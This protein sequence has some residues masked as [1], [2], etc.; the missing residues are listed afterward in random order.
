MLFAKN[1]KLIMIGDSV[2]DAGREHPVGEYGAGRGM[3]YVSEVNA[4]LTTCYPELKMRV[5]NMGTSGNNVLDLANRWQT[6]VFDL[7]PAWVSV[8]IGIN[9]IW[10]QFDHPLLTEL[11]V[12]L[13][14]YTETL[15]RLIAE[16]LPRVKGM[17]LISPYYLEPNKSDPMRAMMDTYGAS[18]KKL[19]EK[20][21]QPFVDLQAAFDDF[22]SYYYP[23]VINWDRVHPNHIGSVIMAKTFLTAVGFDWS[24]MGR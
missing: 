19:A 5:V 12:S 1:D 11:H 3:G 21:K 16:T 4:L 6:D 20:Y 14:Q 13:E 17:I 24:R 10:R 9:D 8:C 18:M 23:S 22:L 15:D 2:T 7:N